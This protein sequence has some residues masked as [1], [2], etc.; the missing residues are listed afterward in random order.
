MLLEATQR[1]GRLLDEIEDVLT[2]ATFGAIVARESVGR[3]GETRLVR[4][5]LLYAVSNGKLRE[6]WPY[7]E[8]QRAIDELWSAPLPTPS[9]M[10]AATPSPVGFGV[11]G[12]CRSVAVSAL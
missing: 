1:S 5:V 8:D 10:R 6:C 7:D 9:H 2:G 12:M 4:R 11:S 3:D